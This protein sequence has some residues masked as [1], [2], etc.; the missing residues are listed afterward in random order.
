MIESRIRR[1]KVVILRLNVA[2]S[3][4]TSLHL[5]KFYRPKDVLPLLRPPSFL[6][7][8]SFFFFFSFLYYENFVCHAARKG[9]LRRWMFRFALFVR[10]M[11]IREVREPVFASVFRNARNVI[12]DGGFFQ[13]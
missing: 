11:R 9:K 12:P 4:S 1:G 3:A 7:S 13:N 8:F 6:P 10:E 5:L 2:A